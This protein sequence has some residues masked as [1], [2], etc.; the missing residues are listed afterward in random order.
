MEIFKEIEKYLNE[1]VESNKKIV[2]KEVSIISGIKE[3]II[4]EKIDMLMPLYIVNKRLLNIILDNDIEKLHIEDIRLIDYFLECI[5]DN[6]ILY[7]GSLDG[8]SEKEVDLTK[9]ITINIKSNEKK[10][11][12]LFQNIYKGSFSSD[13][14]YINNL[15]LILGIDKNNNFNINIDIENID[16]LYSS[17]LTNISIMIIANLHKN[18]IYIFDNKSITQTNK[19]LLNSLEDYFIK[20]YN[21]F[22][23]ILPIFLT[24]LKTF[25]KIV[26]KENIIE[27]I[28]KIKEDEFYEIEEILNRMYKNKIDYNNNRNLERVEEVIRKYKKEK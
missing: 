27:L 19:E 26:G 18:N 1:K 16:F 7:I 9:R 15:L 13:L 2:I 10:T 24:D 5:K 4:A 14:E 3:E 11:I 12:N 17:I 28:E 23:D 6:D 20:F 8:K 21:L 22:K 25:I